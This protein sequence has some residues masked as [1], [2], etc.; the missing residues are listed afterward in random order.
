[1][2][3]LTNQIGMLISGVLTIGVCALPVALITD[4]ALV[5]REK[6]IGDH[7]QETP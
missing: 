7:A 5:L 3:F 1:M 6:Q 2:A 4:D